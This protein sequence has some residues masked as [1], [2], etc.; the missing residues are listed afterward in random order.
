MS[1]STKRPSDDRGKKIS[2]AEGKKKI[3]IAVILIALIVAVAVILIVFTR[4]G[5]SAE[6]APESQGGTSI[7][8]Q[9]Y[10][11][12]VLP[13]AG[14][15]HDVISIEGGGTSASEF[16]G[17][18]KLDEITVYKFDGHDRGI[19]LTAVDNYTFVYSAQDG[20]LNIDFDY[21][22][23]TDSEYTYSIDGDKLTM[24]RSGMDYVLTRSDTP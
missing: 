17:T 8:S 21:D 14:D 9:Y 22:G 23:A 24:S 5:E 7:I 19:M 10:E 13:T 3:L 20:K 11:D 4:G 6:N 15:R 1:A 18:W 16:L 2:S 12:G